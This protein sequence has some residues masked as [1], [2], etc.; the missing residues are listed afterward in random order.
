MGFEVT[1]GGLDPDPVTSEGGQILPAG[2]QLHISPA[3]GQCRPDV[4]A[5]RP[6]AEDRDP[7]P[8]T[9]RPRQRFGRMSLTFNHSLG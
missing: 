9:S 5:N 4:R 3:T 7:H 8:P 2:D 6:G 1:A